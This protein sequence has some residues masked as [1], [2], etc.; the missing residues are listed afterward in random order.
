MREFR[1]NLA[2]SWLLAMVLGVFATSSFVTI[3][4]CSKSGSDSTIDRKHPGYAVYRKYCRSCHQGGLANSPI[5]GNA[6]DWEPRIAKGRDVLLENTIKGMPPGMPKKGLCTGCT[7]EELEDAIDYMIQALD[8]EQSSE[9]NSE[10]PAE[11]Q[12]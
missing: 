6:E 3:A 7:D 4:G 9:L 10:Q 8:V 11:S 12:D 2:K 1:R 5:F